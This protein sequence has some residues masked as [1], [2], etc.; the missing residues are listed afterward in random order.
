M[1]KAKI[2]KE[3]V[4]EAVAGIKTFKNSNEV[5]DFYRFIHENNLR[6]EASKIV[7]LVLKTIAPP[8]KKRGRKKQ[9]LH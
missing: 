3:E 7:S 6:D 1:A 2:K 9:V 5:R 4:S 8:K